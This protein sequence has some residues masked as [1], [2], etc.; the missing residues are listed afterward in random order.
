MV[1]AEIS[2]DSLVIHESKEKAPKKTKKSVKKDPSLTYRLTSTPMVK[3][4]CSKP[5]NFKHFNH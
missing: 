3:H 1:L 2:G 5:A 4:A